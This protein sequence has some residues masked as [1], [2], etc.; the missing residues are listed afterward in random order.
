MTLSTHCLALGMDCIGK[1]SYYTVSPN[2]PMCVGDAVYHHFVNRYCN[3]TRNVY[4]C[5]KHFIY[6]FF[7]CKMIYDSVI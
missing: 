6:L 1:F 4:F 3:N 2:T 7:L 5:K